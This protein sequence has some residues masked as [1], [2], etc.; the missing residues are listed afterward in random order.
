MVLLVSEKFLFD[1]C[2]GVYELHKGTGN[3]CTTFHRDTPLDRVCGC[4]A[5]NVHPELTNLLFMYK[6]L[7]RVSR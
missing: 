2:G 7:C 1:L 6:K 4:N 3:C 5:F